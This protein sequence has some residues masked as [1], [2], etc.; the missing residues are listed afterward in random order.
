MRRKLNNARDVTF[1][2]LFAASP[3]VLSTHAFRA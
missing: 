2:P 3:M 1:R